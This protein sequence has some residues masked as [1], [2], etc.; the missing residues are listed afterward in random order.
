MQASP[1]PHGPTLVVAAGYAVL[2]A[3]IGAW[4]RH[5]DSGLALVNWSLT[6]KLAEVSTL[7]PTQVVTT[8]EVVANGIL[9]IPVG[10]IVAWWWP[11]ATIL[12]AGAAA[13]A[14]ALVIEVVQAFAPI[15]RTTALSDV[16]ANTAG[17]LVG[18]EIARFVERHPRL[19]VPGLAVLTAVVGGVFAVLVWGLF[20]ASA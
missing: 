7:T 1:R 2:L 4:P 13:L 12:H 10:L 6:R 8:A 20:T 16:L 11:R 19:R 3:A 14:L 15:D 17:G 9:F 18:F 5:V